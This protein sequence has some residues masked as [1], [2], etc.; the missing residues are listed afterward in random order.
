MCWGICR[1]GSRKIFCS[2]IQALQPRLVRTWALNKAMLVQLAAFRSVWYIMR[3]SRQIGKQCNTLRF[4]QAITMCAQ[5]LSVLGVLMRG[6]PGCPAVASA[7]VGGA[8]LGRRQPGVV[9]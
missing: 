2:R 5:L 7:P 8:M 3:G 4:G 6:L 9:A 1:R